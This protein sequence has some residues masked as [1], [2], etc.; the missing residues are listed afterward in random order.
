[1]AL[2]KGAC[3]GAYPRNKR[4]AVPLAPGR[5]LSDGYAARLCF[6]ERS[7]CQH[8]DALCQDRA[9]RFSEVADDFIVVLVVA[10]QF[11]E[12]R[13]RKLCKQLESGLRDHGFEPRGDLCAVS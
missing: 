8:G 13:L 4:M 5:L 12:G 6:S 1:M 3:Q 7:R 2:K 9:G 10:C 11:F